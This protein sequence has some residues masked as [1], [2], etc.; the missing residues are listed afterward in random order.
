[1]INYDEKRKWFDE[2]LKD[3]INEANE[4]TKYNIDLKIDHTYKTVQ[5]MEAI[6]SDIGL[7]GES[8]ELA[9]IIALYHDVGR[10]PQLKEFGHFNDKLSINHAEKS[11]EVL[12]ECNVLEDFDEH[13]KNVVYQAILNHNK[14]SIPEEEKDEDVILYSKLIRDAD[15]VDIYRVM[16]E[17]L[18]NAKDD[19]KETLKA[20]R[21]D[22]LEITDHVYDMI[23]SDKKMKISDIKTLGDNYMWN[24]SWAAYD[25]NFDIAVKII[26]EKDYLKQMLAFLEGADKSEELYN[27]IIEVI[28]ERL[29]EE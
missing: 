3:Y 5:A 9:R 2:Y 4:V 28:K 6:A 15:K 13:T 10:F 20:G 19:V 23:M 7:S 18:L 11:V 22:S 26:L 27:H 17:K 12:K 21:V 25:M 1:M 29:K 24:I 8:F 14:N 16:I